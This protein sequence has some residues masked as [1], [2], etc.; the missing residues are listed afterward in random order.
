MACLPVPCS[1]RRPASS[2]FIDKILRLRPNGRVIGEHANTPAEWAQLGGMW[3]SSALILRKQKPLQAWSAA[4]FACECLLKG[5]AM[6][7]LQLNSWPSRE[8]AKS[9]GYSVLYT[10]KLGDIAAL[11]GISVSADDLIAPHWAVLMQ[12]T[13]F[14]MYSVTTDTAPIVMRQL[15]NAAVGKEGVF[16]WLKTQIE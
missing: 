1:Q 11:A 16:Q 7:K 5:L 6:Q 14:H 15:I 13:R 8:F 10:H 12:W 4:G 2:H 9:A 3:S